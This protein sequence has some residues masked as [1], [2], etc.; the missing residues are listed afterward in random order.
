MITLTFTAGSLPPNFCPATWQLTFQGFVNALS[1]TVNGLDN[2]QV[3]VSQTAPAISTSYLWLQI[4]VGGAPIQLY[5]ASGGVWVPN[6][7]TFFFPGLADIGVANSYQVTGVTIPVSVNPDGSPATGLVTGM[8]FVFMAGHSNTAASTFQVNAYTLQT[9]LIGANATTAGQIVAGNWYVVLYDGTHF[10]LLNPS[11]GY[12]L[13]TKFVSSLQT[14]PV[15]G[16]NTSVAQPL[17]QI[18]SFYQVY[19]K[20]LN[21]NNGWSAGDIVSPEAFVRDDINGKSSVSGTSAFY[22]EPTTT[23]FILYQKNCSGT[24]FKVIIK[25]GDYAAGAT[26]ESDWQFYVSMGYVP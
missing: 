2:T 24:L 19:F 22:Y 7:P 12:L 16:A 25:G 21:P 20:C 5:R 3:L 10:Q 14:V 18:P 11:F 4:S 23:S 17:N 13:T 1:A 8:T 26:N 15:G 9:L 6:Q